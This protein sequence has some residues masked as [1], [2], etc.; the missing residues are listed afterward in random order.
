VWVRVGWPGGEVAGR[1]SSR[2]GVAAPAS[3]LFVVIG[4]SV[5]FSQLRVDQINSRQIR[6]LER[7]SKSQAKQAALSQS[8]F[9]VTSDLARRMNRIQTDQLTRA[10]LADPRHQ[11]PKKL[12]RYEYKVWSQNGEDGII[13]E[14]FRRIGTTN[15]YFVEF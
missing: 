13:A 2:G 8:L 9:D 6:L 7:I 14:I 12:N 1:E 3:L 10:I 4:G 15:R 5:L 11:D